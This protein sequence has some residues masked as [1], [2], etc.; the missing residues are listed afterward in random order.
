[1]YY[2]SQCRCNSCV[3]ARIMEQQQISLPPE[4]LYEFLTSYDIHYTPPPPPPPPPE[5]QQQQ[6]VRKP[7]KRR[8]STTT[9][10]KPHKKKRKREET[11]QQQQQHTGSSSSSS[12][13]FD[14]FIDDEERRVV[15]EAFQLKM[16]LESQ[17]V[18]NEDRIKETETKIAL[19]QSEL[20]V[21]RLHSDECRKKLKHFANL[22]SSLPASIP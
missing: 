16:V 1:M 4:E 8:R 9:P 3:G 20:Q 19:L 18:R 12:G 6:Q 13:W 2:K 21:A 14:T 22:A 15:C 5:V 7:S 11:V 17:L 10:P